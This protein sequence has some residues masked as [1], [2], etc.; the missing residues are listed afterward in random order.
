MHILQLTVYLSLL[1]AGLFA[2][3][4]LRQR[5]DTENQSVEQDALQPLREETPKNVS[6][7][8]H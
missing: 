3:S 4:F 7:N 6:K 1:L 2:L 8:E 5:Q